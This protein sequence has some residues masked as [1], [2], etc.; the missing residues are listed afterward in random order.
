MDDAGLQKAEE[1]LHTVRWS[2]IVIIAGELSR[3]D[4][5][6]F[7]RA[8]TMGVSTVCD[9]NTYKPVHKLHSSVWYCTV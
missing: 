7:A 1:S 3:Q 9:G 2:Y 5:W 4:Y 8:Y 6:H